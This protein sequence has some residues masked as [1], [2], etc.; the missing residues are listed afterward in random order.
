MKRIWVG[1]VALFFGLFFAIMAFADLQNDLIVDQ[2]EKFG[3]SISAVKQ[4]AENLQNVGADVHIWIMKSYSKTADNLDQQF[5]Q[6]LT[7]NKA[8]QSANG[9]RKNN[10]I[11]FM[12][13]MKERQTGLYYGGDWD[14][15]LAD[16]WKRIVADHMNPKF[17]QGKFADGFI[18]GINET[19]RVIYKHLH[20]SNEQQIIVH[21]GSSEVTRG[22]GSSTIIIKPSNVTSKPADYSGLWTVLKWALGLIFVFALFY[23]GA[24]FFISRK[25]E[26]EK[27]RG[28]QQKAKIEKINAA[29]KV[30]VIRDGISEIATLFAVIKS[31]LDEETAKDLQTDFD[32]IK[33]SQSSLA[34]DFSATDSSAG[35][36]D[37]QNLNVPQY[38]AIEEKYGEISD[39]AASIIKSLNQLRSKIINLRDLISKSPEL[40]KR[41][42]DS[43]DQ[44]KTTIMNVEKEG[45]KVAVAYDILLRTKEMVSRAKENLGKKKYLIF[46]G[47]ANKAL[48]EMKK[49]ENSALSMQEEKKYIDQNIVNLKERIPQAVNKIKEGKIA[50]EVISRI[51]APPCWRAVRGNG[52][53]AENRIHWSINALK[54]AQAKASLE[55][56]D[57]NGA[58]E[59]L[60]QV[61]KW[62]DQ[63]ESYIR[64]IIALKHNLEQA[65]ANVG[66]EISDAEKDIRKAW[67]YIKKYDDDIRESLEDDLR[68]AEKMI[69]EAKNELT[70]ELPDYIL[71]YKKAQEAN[72]LADHIYEEAVD[73]H[74]S[75]E[76]LRRQ[77]ISQRQTT[78]SAISRAKEYIEDHDDD[79]ESEAKNRL[80]IAEN[81]LNEANRNMNLSNIIALAAL[82]E[83]EANS[84]YER[85]K[86]DVSSAS[87]DSSHNWGSQTRYT[88]NDDSIFSGGGSIS[89]GGGGGGGG[90]V[91]W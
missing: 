64:S 82:A 36:P 48:D 41:L 78:E 65:K 52:T 44:A 56:Q 24:R 32:K 57:W 53:E 25:K 83:T 38:Q 67:D 9:G 10:L 8:W 55:V 20:P 22:E 54:S 85:A 81:K 15:P 89:F 12:L 70:L 37:A 49:A 62:L 42:E 45:F 43:M 66:R 6:L 87:F 40:I 7:K 19:K 79:V 16:H 60:S 30:S 86:S 80:S 73:E 13:S 51:F 27:R 3:S 74:E 23:F 26:E 61:S 72:S 11:V 39:N 2:A 35:D 90:S 88:S 76:R 91:G 31:N 50:F 75:A 77:A 1:T 59:E 63:A 17:K 68:D 18:N 47:L 69:A 84:A 58:K 34:E 4:A 33:T 71:A 46:S 28:A 29:K 5:E 21:D 14:G